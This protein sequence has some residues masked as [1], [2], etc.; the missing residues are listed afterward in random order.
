MD[1]D[2][3]GCWNGVQVT[4]LYHSPLC[5]SF[6]SI[7]IYGTICNIWY[8]SYYSE[9]SSGFEKKVTDFWVC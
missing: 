4:D 8:G 9:I 1:T 3:N 2:K 5:D 6:V 7:I